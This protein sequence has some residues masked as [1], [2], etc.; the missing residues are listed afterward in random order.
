[1]GE[2]RPWGA[3]KELSLD[4]QGFKAELLPR[5]DCTILPD[6]GRGSPAPDQTPAPG[7]WSGALQRG[8]ILAFTVITQLIIRKSFP[9]ESQASMLRND[10]VYQVEENTRKGPLPRPLPAENI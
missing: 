3:H 7:Q 10:A 5:P 9:E 4:K 2:D 6:T 1:M 8:V